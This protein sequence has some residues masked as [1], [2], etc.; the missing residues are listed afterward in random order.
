MLEKIGLP[1]KPSLRGNNW[2]VDASHC[3][4][5]SSQFT[6]IN[7]KHHC[8]RCGGLFCNSCTQQRMFL[9]GQGDSPVRICDPCKKLEEAARFELRHGHKGRAPKGGSKS[10]VKSEDEIFNQLLG[11]EK[12]SLLPGQ[13][14]S[15]SIVSHLL[16]ATGT[17]S[18]SALEEGA[19]TP[20]R[21]GGSLKSLIDVI[22]SSS[23]DELR[24]QALEEKKKYKTLKG[25]GKPEE[26]LQ[27]FKRGK[28]LERKAGALDIALR[29]NRRKA[30]M[31]NNSAS[32]QSLKDASEELITKNVQASTRKKDEKD[33]LTSELRELGWSDV[34]LHVTDKKPKNIS[35]EGELS[36]ILGEIPKSNIAG[37]N[38]GIDKTQVIAHKRKALSLKREGKLAEAKEE[39]KKAKV[40][41]KQ[42]EEQEF[43]AEA[44]DSDDELSALMRGLD[45]DKQDGLLHYGKDDGF[46]LD[47]LSSVADDIAAEG[48]LEV[49]DDDMYDPDIAV[50]LESFGWTEDD[51]Q[52]EDS[53][54]KPLS[55]NHEALQNEMLSLKREAVNQKRAGN[56]AEA[57]DLLKKAKIIEKNLE[58]LQ[59]SSESHI[60]KRS[61][62]VD[63]E[64]VT[65]VMDLDFKPPRKSKLV[66]QRELLNLKKKALALRREGRVDEAEEELKKG[67]ALERQLEEMENVPKA[68][69]PKVN[70]GANN[71][72]LASF[73]E[74]EEVDTDVTEQDLHDPNLLSMLHNIGW[75]NDSVSVER[76]DFEHHNEHS[77]I[78]PI[79]AKASKS[80]SEIQ[81]ELLGLKRKA[82]TLR[83]QG[84][85][86]EAEEELKKAKVLEDEMAAMEV[87]IPSGSGT[88]KLNEAAL[89]GYG[90]MSSSS[91][92]SRGKEELTVEVD[93]GLVKPFQ[94]SD[95]NEADLPKPLPTSSK[96]STPET[97][98]RDSVSVTNAL[99]TVSDEPVMASI[100]P[101]QQGSSQNQDTLIDRTSPQQ[102]ILA[103]K[104]KAVS[105][106]RE[107]KIAE[108][109]EELRQAKLLERS[110]E[111][112]SLHA[113][114]DST[115]SVV[116]PST[117]DSASTVHENNANQV[118]KPLSGRDRFKLQQQSLAHK[119]QALKLRREGRM[120]ESEA[121]FEKAKV[122]ESQLEE[123]GNQHSSKSEQMDDA[124][125]EDL[126]D[127]QLLSA[128]KAVGL[129]DL[130]VPVNKPQRVEAKPE[131]NM[132][133]N[134]GLEKVQLE[135]QI[136][137][138]KMRALN[139]KRAG[140]Q[141]EALEALR[142]AKR[143]QK[144]LE[145]LAS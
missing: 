137:S 139:L 67:K 101:T 114:T 107:G 112:D 30:S 109:R 47:Y 82:L 78:P 100:Q 28:E 16:G 12:Q 69:P 138:E 52:P 96:S 129:Q 53:V 144:K 117:S 4:G 70:V 25:E 127:P 92:T 135:E 103:H 66:I 106:K 49:N 102:E 93:M 34:D 113:N 35:L 99:K 33:D 80:K 7:R 51:D 143:L 45:D 15:S 11:D 63:D 121:E 62:T 61:S 97:N 88:T 2:V 18:S 120:E 17:A 19:A 31:S 36:S 3:Q 29:K 110:S 141:A 14:P 13:E 20:E 126:L 122:L 46:N 124:G 119:R 134:I 43:L 87:Q 23:P 65:E 24:K 79:P 81:K 131:S 128:L 123:L 140:K 125:V 27:A 54:L 59:T 8:R 1:P 22:D 98:P 71:L 26:A 56:I 89:E 58:G 50:A 86:E 75:T 118:R 74:E 48:N 142:S 77:S 94:S 76:N 21:I 111:V 57:M 6:F 90:D 72:A 10:S 68:S 9:R 116:V 38:G 73:H 91:K 115:E 60:S 130:D 41:E 40:L 132:S 64:G 5:C 55:T 108:A 42:I 105:L 37:K 104:R 95:R 32:S 44:D 83:R 85:L 136:K 145:S 39:L 133:A 84:K